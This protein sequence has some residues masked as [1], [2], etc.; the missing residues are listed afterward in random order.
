[1]SAREKGGNTTGSARLKGDC[2]GLSIIRDG[3]VEMAISRRSWSQGGEVFCIHARRPPKK[4]LA[5][6]RPRMASVESIASRVGPPPPSACF[7]NIVP[8][9]II[10]LA[11]PLPVS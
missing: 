6:S 3:V 8:S 4:L 11:L 5:Y 1:M 7:F 10:G 2:R 9:R